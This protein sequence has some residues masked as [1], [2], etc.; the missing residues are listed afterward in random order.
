MTAEWN[1]PS[2]ATAKLVRMS[3]MLT[4]AAT[5]V[6]PMTVSGIPIVNP[7]VFVK[8]ESDDAEREREVV[9]RRTDN[10][11]HPD[12]DVRKDGDPEHAHKERD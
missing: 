10:G 3:G 9:V 5:N 4:P 7:F 8:E 1:V 2:L 6:K 12:H 11:D